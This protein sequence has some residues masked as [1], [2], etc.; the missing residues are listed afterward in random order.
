MSNSIL[1][2]LDSASTRYKRRAILE[3]SYESSSFSFYALKGT[4]VWVY[5]E[6]DAE[7]RVSREASK[8]DWNNSEWPSSVESNP[9]LLDYRPDKYSFISNFF[10]FITPSFFVSAV[11]G[12]A[13]RGEDD[14]LIWLFYTFIA[15][16]GGTGEGGLIL[17]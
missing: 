9:E 2:F 15:V 7:G 11:A 14:F 6:D 17:F 1:I 3:T 8:R 16:W 12:G 10:L 5:W 13:G 4:A